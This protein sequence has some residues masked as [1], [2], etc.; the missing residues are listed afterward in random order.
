VRL[1]VLHVSQP[2]DGGVAR[3][4]S[5]LVADQVARG[6]SVAV[7][8]P[9]GPLADSVRAAGGRHVLWRSGR[10]PGPAS[11]VEAARLG[12]IVRRE[13]PDLLHLHSSKAGLAGRLAVRE[14]IP[15]LF[16]PHAWSFHALGGLLGRAA[17]SWE[18]LGARWATAIVCVSDG[19]RAEG[20]AVGIRGR[21][22]VVPNGVDLDAFTVASDEDRKVARREL[23]LEDGPLAVAVGRLSRQKGV[24]VLLEAWPAVPRRV[25]GAQLVVVG[26]G[27]EEEAL[28]RNAGTARMVGARDD[29][30]SWLAAADVVVAPSRW[31]GLA[32]VVLEAMATGRPVVASDVAGMREALGDTGAIVPTEDPQALADALADALK[33]RDGTGTRERIER[34]YD[35]RRSTQ[36]MADLYAEVLGSSSQ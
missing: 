19:E 28:R 5:D 2:V 26:S 32:Y 10:A 9:D 17:L 7:A 33:R 15:T 3:S 31:E 12:P 4:V 18:R 35:V 13:A 27:P 16:Q 23:G 11:L 14:K 6:W 24:D 25:D 22:A 29:V 34:L 8:S 36:A 30:R 21:W 1:S 20:E